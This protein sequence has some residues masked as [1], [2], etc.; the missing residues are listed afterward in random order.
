[1]Y[2]KFQNFTF[3]KE[4]KYNHFKGPSIQTIEE[5]HDY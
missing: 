5:T 1:M 3:T 4:F 2:D